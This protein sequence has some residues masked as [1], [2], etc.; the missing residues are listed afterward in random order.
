MCRVYELYHGNNMEIMPTLKAESIDAIITDPPYELG[1]MNKKWDKSGIA[2]NVDMWREC[3]RVLKPGGYLLSFGG[4]RTYHRIACAIEDAGFVIHPMIAWIFGSGFP[5]ATNLSKQFDK[6]AGAEREVVGKGKAGKTALG[7]S[8][9]WN[10]TYNPHE[11]SI[12]TSTTP[13]AKQWDGWYYGLQ[14]LKPAIEPICMA[15]K[16]ID[17][18]RMTDNVRKWGVGAI[19][20]DGCRVGNSI[21]HNS[22]C[23][24]KQGYMSDEKGASGG[25][26]SKE[27]ANIVQGR[28]PANVILDGSEEVLS[29]FAKAGMSR[30]KRQKVSNVGTIWGAKNTTIDIR[31]HN[32]FGTPARFFY[33]SKASKAE[34]NMGLDG[35][36][37]STVD[38]GRQKAIDNPFQRGKTPRKNTHPTVKPIALMRYLCRLVTPPNGTILDPFMG[39][40]S[41]I[42]ASL[43]KGFHAIGIEKESEYLEIAKR[44]IEAV[45]KSKKH[46]SFKQK[47][48]VSNDQQTIFDLTEVMLNGMDAVKRI[49]TR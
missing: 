34:R 47:V 13:E 8:S 1:F 29:E 3:L 42:I 15:Q 28:F 39:S 9:G 6:Q 26:F 20:V 27:G 44:R 5:K 43:Q 11:Y 4:T 41:T 2:Y 37:E 23:K 32:D 21:F 40:G 18:K 36:N 33:C 14:S 38:D 49:Y 35:K 31:G 17:G 16:P 45:D 10:K 7:Q 48:K 30:S 22:Y 12:T 24:P 19:N 25:A 46:F